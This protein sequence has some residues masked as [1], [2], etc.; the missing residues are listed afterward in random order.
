MDGPYW[1]KDDD[2]EMPTWVNA[3]G[4]R[5]AWRLRGD[6]VEGASVGF[7]RG[8]LSADLTVLSGFFV[9][10]HDH[11]PIHLEAG[12]ALDPRRKTGQFESRDGRRFY[13]RAQLAT[14]GEPPY[15]PESFEISVRPFAP[16]SPGSAVDH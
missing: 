8:A 4:A 16:E 14:E 3:A 12:D 1:R 9:G 7:Q 5:I 10:N 15:G 6:R 11:L 2:A 13:Y